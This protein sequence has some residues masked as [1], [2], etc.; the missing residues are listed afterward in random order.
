MLESSCNFSD[1]FPMFNLCFF[2]RCADGGTTMDF[3]DPLAS[4]AGDVPGPP[5]PEVPGLQLTTAGVRSRLNRKKTRSKPLLQIK[6]AGCRRTTWDMC[7]FIPTDYLE[8]GA[9]CVFIPQ[10]WHVS[11]FGV[12]WFDLFDLY[13]PAKMT[14]RLDLQVGPGVLPVNKAHEGYGCD[15]GTANRPLLFWQPANDYII[16]LMNHSTVNYFFCAI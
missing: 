11:F 7:K 8:P 10:I 13:M 3:D 15:R 14:P 2:G 4:L 1:R 9:Q 12:I 5:L 16:W 6:C